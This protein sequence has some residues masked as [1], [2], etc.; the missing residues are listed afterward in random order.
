MNVKEWH[1]D[2]RAFPILILVIELIGFTIFSQQD[3]SVLNRNNLQGL[4]L[5]WHLNFLYW[6]LY[7][8]YSAVHPQSPLATILRSRGCYDLIKKTSINTD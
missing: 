1:S 2:H 7:H 6:L 4:I 3:W 5:G 8:G